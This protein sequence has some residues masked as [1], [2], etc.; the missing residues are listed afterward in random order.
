MDRAKLMNRT[1]KPLVLMV[2]TVFLG[3]TASAEK[4]QL[5]AG[6]GGVADIGAISCDVFN[7]MIVIGPLGTKRLLLTWAQGYYHAKSGKTIDELI[8]TAEKTGQ[9]W[10]FDSLTGH[11][12]DYCAAD[13]EAL[14]SAAVVDLGERLLGTPAP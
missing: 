2:F 7:K 14:T 5:P 10:D 12:V 8:E 11:F 4:L 1:I 13:P 3:N 6:M 9:T